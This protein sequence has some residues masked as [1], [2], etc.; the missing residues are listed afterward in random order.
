MNEEKVQKAKDASNRLS[1]FLTAKGLPAWVAKA[2]AGAIVGSVIAVLAAVQSACTV[3]SEQAQGLQLI[4]AYL[5]EYGYLLI[6]VDD[7][8]K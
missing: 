7:S 5:H 8:E 6:D 1:A 2:I 3:T 4:D